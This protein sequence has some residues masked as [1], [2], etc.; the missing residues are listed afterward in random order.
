PPSSHTSV[1]LRPNLADIGLDLADQRAFESAGGVVGV[2][3]VDDQIAEEAALG[4]V[5]DIE[6]HAAG[7]SVGAAQGDGGEGDA[8]DIAEITDDAVDVDGGGSVDRAAGGKR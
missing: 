5:D 7:H 1:Q 3:G 8:V 6:L 2:D 4:R